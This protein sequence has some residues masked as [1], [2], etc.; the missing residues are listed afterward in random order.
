MSLPVGVISAISRFV[1]PTL[2]Q[3]CDRNV[4]QEQT[5]DM[6]QTSLTELWL[7]SHVDIHEKNSVKVVVAVYRLPY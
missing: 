6:N 5:P 4:I 7:T 1:I 2:P 3:V